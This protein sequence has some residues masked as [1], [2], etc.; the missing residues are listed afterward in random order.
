MTHLPVIVVVDDVLLLQSP[1][2]ESPEGEF[3]CGAS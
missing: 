2:A 3:G 1:K